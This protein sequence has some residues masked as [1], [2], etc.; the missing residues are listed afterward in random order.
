MTTLTTDAE[1]NARW[2]AAWLGICAMTIFGMILLGGVTRLTESGLSMVDWRP[3]MGVIPPLTEIQWLETFAAYQQYPEYQK[4]NQGMDLA[5]FK[6]I[7]WFEYLHR[8]LGRLIGLMYFIPLVIFAM[9]RMIA[10]Q[11]LPTLI[12]LFF[13]GAAQGLLGWYM[14]KSGLVD[15]PSVS[16]YR[17]T[18][19]LGVAVAIYTLMMWLL[20]RVSAGLSP[21]LR[22]IEPIGVLLLVG[23]YILILSG[24]FMAGT[25]AGFAYPTWPLMGESFV[26]MGY[27]AEGWRATFESVATIHFNHRMLAYVIALLVLFVS[28]RSLRH[29]TQPKVKWGA[30][31]MLLALTF[32]VLLGIGTVLSQVAIPMA[33]THQVGAVVL[34][35]TV[36]FWSHAH[37]DK[38]LVMSA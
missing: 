27:Y 28:V 18:A 33:A 37:T 19:H 12:L 38:K 17:L 31:L 11:L 13:L 1:H 16:Q 2:L 30:V 35:T 15:R 6:Q 25:D 32:Q 5:G 9:R 20:F 34:L 3:I 22:Q 7:F 4:I 24:G 21:S 29:S 36:L 23:V 8:V 14:V 10:P 26:P